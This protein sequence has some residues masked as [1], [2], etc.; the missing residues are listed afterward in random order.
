MAVLLLH[1]ADSDQCSCEAGL[2]LADDAVAG[3][4]D[5]GVAD[6]DVAAAR[7]AGAAVAA[8]G[9]PDADVAQNLVA[10]AGVADAAVVVASD[11]DVT[12]VTSLSDAR[13]RVV[14]SV[15][16]FTFVRCTFLYRYGI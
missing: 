2:A 5:A 1:F 7:V 16:V 12:L 6:A 3:M 11:A 10:E 9:I 14:S 15:P 8:A 4:A 13:Q